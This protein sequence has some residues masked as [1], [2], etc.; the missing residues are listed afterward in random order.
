MQ[1]TVIKYGGDKSI[2][3]CDYFEFRTNRVHNYIT[4]LK[5]G[6]ITETIEDIAV[7]KAGD[8][9]ADSN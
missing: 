5:D 7:I 6:K 2:H 4:F 8:K 3:E 1:I 9:N